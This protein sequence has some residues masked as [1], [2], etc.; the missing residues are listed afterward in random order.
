M[1]GTAGVWAEHPK[2]ENRLDANGVPELVITPTSPDAVRKVEMFY[3]LKNPCS[4]ARS[5]RDTPSVR[6][7]QQWVAK[8]PVLKVDD[9]V[10]G[11]ANITYDTTIVRSTDFNA[12]IPAKHGKAVATDQL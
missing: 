9:Y 4:Y 5:W 6:Q 1:V 10:F 11:Y 3:A 12:A 2:S 8:M 7:G